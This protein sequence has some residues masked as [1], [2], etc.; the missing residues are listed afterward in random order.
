MKPYEEL[1]RRG[2]ARRIRGL[3]RAALDAYGLIPARF[4]LVA[5]AGNALYRIYTRE[6]LPSGSCDGLFEEDQLLLRLHW[7]GYRETEAIRAE[8]AWLEAM[9]R[10]RQLPVP[11]PMPT[12]G[13]ELLTKVSVAGVPEARDCS[14]L[15]WVKGRRLGERARC[16]HYRA[17]GRLMAELHTFASGWR[18]SGRGRERR[19][20]WAGMFRTTPALCLPV[21][22]VWSLLSPSSRALFEAVAERVRQV[23]GEL[24]D[25]P[26]AFGLIHADLGVD[27]NLLFSGGQARA[28][29]FDELGLGYWVY[30][31][32]VALEHCREDPRFPRYRSALLTGYSEI[33]TLPERQ[34]QHIELFMAGLDVYLGLWANAVM[35]L[36]PNP[37]EYVRTRAARSVRLVK[38]YLGGS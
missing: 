2:R 36:Y 17:Q 38:Q 27:A 15:R 13:G 18:R 9:R 31:L 21:S 19:Y 35:H 33:R 3:A 32:A 14:L 7:P 23:M 5:L 28:I 8:L 37:S 1:T 10:E 22:D 12:P 6:A 4:S 34:I 11:E 20:D 25:G 30:D 26:D 29:D 16:R 24:G